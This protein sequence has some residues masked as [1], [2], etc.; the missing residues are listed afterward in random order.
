MPSIDDLIFLPYSSDLNLAGIAYACRSLPYT[1][2]RVGG[3]RAERLRRIV[4]GIAVELAFRRHL[5]TKNIPYDLL[6]ATP[7]TQPD[8]YDLALGGRRCDIK[9]YIIHQRDHIRQIR[10]NPE[11]VLN[12]S[13]LVPVDQISSDKL[14]DED[15]YVFVFLTALVT[16]NLATLEKAI[17]AEQ[18]IYLLH[19]LPEKWSRPASWVS[20]DPLILKGNVSFNVRLEL[21]G[22]DV[23]RKFQIYKLELP[24]LRRMV[25]ESGFFSLTYVHI[26]H[27]PDG[28]VGVHSPVLGETVLISR[29]MWG[30]LWVYGMEV[31][32]VGY[33]P[34]GEFRRK[35][36]YLPEGS[37][38]FQYRRTRTANL[39]L[40]M[41][42]LRPISDLFA[43]VKSWAERGQRSI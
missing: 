16:P 38:V 40:P 30:N 3:T 14:G 7:F 36:T 41:S 43:R 34:Q 21:G 23:K 26:S 33:L 10:R 8:R 18:P 32:L 29:Q 31:I 35:A 42:E 20:L 22:Q 1:Y 28:T 6:G 4:A 19:H 13:A 2:D 12:A 11:V 27:L 9:S 15:I 24:P 17:Q 39:A 37:R 25:I 5:D